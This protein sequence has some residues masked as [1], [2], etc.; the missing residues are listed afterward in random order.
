M[1]LCSSKKNFPRKKAPERQLNFPAGALTIP[2]TLEGY[3]ELIA[4]LEDQVKSA[5]S[6]ALKQEAGEALSTQGYTWAYPAGLKWLL[7]FGALFFLGMAAIS[8]MLWQSGEFTWRQGLLVGGFFS[9]FGLFSGWVAYLF[10]GQIELTEKALIEYR[11]FSSKKIFFSD[12]ESAC[13]GS[14]WGERCYTLRGR[15]EV[16]RISSQLAGYEVLLETLQA[17]VAEVIAQEPLKPPFTVRPSR[18]SFAGLIGLSGALFFF[19]WLMFKSM[20]PLVLAIAAGLALG[21]IVLLLRLPLCYYFL[22]D[23]VRISFLF[24]KQCYPVR[25]LE[26]IRLTKTSQNGAAAYV[27]QLHTPKRKFEL[28]DAAINRAPQEIYAALREAYTLPEEEH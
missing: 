13:W 4:L 8:G 16:I 28:R 12:L 5:S 27:L 2:P 7:S 20:D 15:G 10:W 21:Y 9:L 19:L 14:Y 25:E 24:R 18:F 1:K 6:K 26:A 3:T 22:E 11:P 23:E 17:R